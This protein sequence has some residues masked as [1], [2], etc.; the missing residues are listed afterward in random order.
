MTN[1]NLKYLLFFRVKLPKT[2]LAVNL[3]D[4][5]TFEEQERLANDHDMLE[6]KAVP[7]KDLLSGGQEPIAHVIAAADTHVEPEE[8][9]EAVS[10]M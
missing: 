2:F 4:A 7:P 10:Q 1:V 3:S 8:P 5:F 9:G 6:M